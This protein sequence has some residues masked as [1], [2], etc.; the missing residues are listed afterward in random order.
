MQFRARITYITKLTT[1][2]KEKDVVLTFNEGKTM[3][4]RTNRLSHK[5]IEKREFMPTLYNSGL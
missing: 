3:A 2:K 4:R 5:K 1:P